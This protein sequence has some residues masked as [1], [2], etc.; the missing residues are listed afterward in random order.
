[1]KRSYLPGGVFLFF[2]KIEKLPDGSFLLNAAA[3]WLLSACAQ[4]CLGSILANA[5]GMGE[6]GVAYLGSALSFLCAA[7]AGGVAS[8]KSKANGLATSLIT[9]SFLIILLLTL[10][11]LIAGRGLDPSLILSLVSFTYAGT[12][13]GTLLTPKSV[14]KSPKHRG[15][16]HN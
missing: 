3:A 4:L 13:A 1:M 7:A 14:K 6:R 8:R 5:A 9:G 15:F 2:G 11:F 16:H 10:G 12:L